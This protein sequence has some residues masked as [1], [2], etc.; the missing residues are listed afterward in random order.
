MAEELAPDITPEAELPREAGR[1]LVVYKGEIT[2]EYLRSQWNVIKTTLCAGAS[3]A[4]VGFLIAIA[5]TL[6]LNPFLKEVVWAEH[7]KTIMVTEAGLLKMAR[8]DPAYRGLNADVVFENDEF[9]FGWDDGKPFCRH[10]HNHK[11]PGKILGAWAKLTM[12]GFEHP[13]FNYT[14]WD[15]ISK[16]GPAWANWEDDMMRKMPIVRVLRMAGIMPALPVEGVKDETMEVVEVATEERHE[17]ARDER[18]TARQETEAHKTQIVA[19]CERMER[20]LSDARFDGWDV[21][22]RRLAS[23][24]KYAKTT[25]LADATVAALTVYANHLSDKLAK[26]AEVQQAAVVEGRTPEDTVYTNKETADAQPE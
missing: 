1:Q 4:E 19:N 26:M 25:S 12:A 7:L 3:D 18:V 22:P 13:I 23:R 14:S 6:N 2:R 10:V 15:R 8:R 11:D 16:K 24:T 17:V 20:Q 9:E 21:K 5:E